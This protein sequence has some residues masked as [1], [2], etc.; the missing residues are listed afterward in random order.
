[1]PVGI[2]SSGLMGGKP[3]R[4]L[5]RMEEPKA[6]N[7][8]TASSDLD[9]ANDTLNVITQHEQQR[10]YALYKNVNRRRFLGNPIVFRV[11]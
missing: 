3:G 6:V 10:T 8:H 7:R 1:M 4:L 11:R 9:I 2:L 5:S